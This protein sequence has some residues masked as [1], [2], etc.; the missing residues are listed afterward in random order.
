[1]TTLREEAVAL[2]ETYLYGTAAEQ[3]GA[4]DE[5]LDRADDDGP[6]LLMAM[7]DRM[8]KI[9]CSADDIT[10]LLQRVTDRGFARVDAGTLT[11]HWE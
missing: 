1:M 3:T 10:R 4:I 11:N 2:V 9:G 7:W 8:R 5:V 6:V